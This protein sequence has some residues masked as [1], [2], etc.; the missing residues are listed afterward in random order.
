MGGPRVPRDERRRHAQNAV[1]AAEEI[2]LN[3]ADSGVAQLPL[4]LAILPLAL[5]RQFVRQAEDFDYRDQS[6]AGAGLEDIDERFR[7][8]LRLEDDPFFHPGGE[9]A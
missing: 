8:R 4:L 1:A 9:A 6:L 2:D 7:G 3:K 5:A